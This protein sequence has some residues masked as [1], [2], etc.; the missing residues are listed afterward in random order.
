MPAMIAAGLLLAGTLAA[1]TDRADPEGTPRRVARE[2]DRTLT[3]VARNELAR[4]PELATR[5]GLPETATGYRHTAYLTDRS[6][7][8]Y[9]RSRLARL[10]TR[11]LLVRVTRPARGSALARHL[12][13]VIAAHETAEAL[14]MAGHGS[15]SLGV[16]YPYVADHTRGAY[17]DVPELLVWLHPLNTPDDAH[18]FIDRMAQFADAIDDDRRRLEADALAGIV[19]P[20][21]ILRRM[22]VS[23][24]SVA[25]GG[26]E[27]SGMLNRFETFLP[28]IA[29]L[30]ADERSQL[31][32]DARRIHATSVMPAYE[33]FAGSLARLANNAPELPGVWQ[34]PEGPAYYAAALRAYSGDDASAA[35]LHERGRREV[36][37]RLVELDRALAGI[38]LAE[39]SAGERLAFLAAQTGQ[40]FPETEEGRAE[41]AERLGLHAARAGAALSGHFDLAAPGPVNFVILPADAG[42]HV[43]LAVYRPAPAN[44]SAPARIEL[45]L[46]RPGDLPDYRLAAV[47]FHQIVPGHH[48][49]H[50][51]ALDAAGLP[52]IR[53][54]IRDVPY[55]EGWGSYAET[56]ADELG[57]Y[58]EDPLSRIGYLQSMLLGAARL[59]TDTGI[60]HER[61]SRD[62]AIAYLV[63]T[64]GL[65][66]PMAAAEVDRFT[67]R[68]GHGAAYW[69]GRER[70]LD[71]RER[72]IRVLGPRFDAKAFHRV[73]LAGGPR[74]LAMVDEDVTRWYTALI[75]E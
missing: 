50:T 16:S 42:Q 14:F 20:A 33:G 47:A 10:E 2:V 70:F 28:S 54:L 3:T 53:Q 66:P 44:G 30:G 60:H 63:E 26:P 61:W 56:L 23:V 18:A 13:T 35:G 15:S 12:D 39:G 9:E 64:T 24:T 71:L 72:A 1:C 51:A 59:V 65:S 11:D 57:L 43:P 68:P 46:S 22:L 38:G 55:S 36:E 40:A 52:L 73:I 48:L 27:A 17:L 29:G 5:L 25:A 6:Q 7:A 69:L 58:S 62:Q 8:A 75:E 32:D 45:N 74:P 34:L 41:L 31:V 37:A 67:V 4:D 49:E 21:P 19:P